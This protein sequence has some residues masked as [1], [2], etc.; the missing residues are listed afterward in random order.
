MK[1][2]LTG[3]TLISAALLAGCATASIP[4]SNLTICTERSQVCTQNYDPVCGQ[5]SDRQW[6]TYANSCTA[7]SNK[8]VVEY[9]VGECPK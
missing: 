6:K 1:K 4:D 2:A 7:C 9:K 8:D 3:L 5:T